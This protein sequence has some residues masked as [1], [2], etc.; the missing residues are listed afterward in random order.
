M[1]DKRDIVV[2]A[3]TGTGKTAAFS[4]PV[5][6]LTDPSS[7]NIQSLILCPTR[8]LCIQITL[9]VESF[10]KYMKG[11]KVT[12]VYGGASISNQISELKEERKW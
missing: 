2:L 1:D 5:I 9:Y 6:S 4:L 12:A 8:E 3:Q 7:S 11:F 10:T